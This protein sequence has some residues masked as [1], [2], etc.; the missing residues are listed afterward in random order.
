MQENDLAPNST[1]S[2]GAVMNLPDTFETEKAEEE[3]S[4]IICNKIC[5][6]NEIELNLCPNHFRCEDCSS[7]HFSNQKEIF[8]KGGGF[9]CYRCDFLI[10]KEKYNKFITSAACYRCGENIRSKFD[11]ILDQYNICRKCNGAMIM[12]RVQGNRSTFQQKKIIETCLICLEQKTMSSS[13]CSTH[14]VC[15]SC[16]AEYLKSSITS[17]FIF[18]ASFS[19]P[20]PKGTCGTLFSSQFIQSYIGH[21]EEFKKWFERSK[22]K[23]SC[24]KCS[25][26][27]V[28]IRT[29]DSVWCKKCNSV[30][31]AIC[32]KQLEQVLRVHSHTRHYCALKEDLSLLNS[33]R[34]TFPLKPCLKCLNYIYKADGC[35][36]M[37]CICGGSFCWECLQPYDQH[38]QRKCKKKNGILA[39]YFTSKLYVYVYA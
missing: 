25:S 29:N 38:D 39:K 13:S 30:F 3:K 15:D 7:L 18:G 36:H 33:V 22:R 16:L 17:S 12:D 9:T 37:T 19:C 5:Y 24:S 6:L 14:Q 27:D 21:T 2:C 34:S 32:F 35:S 8:K 23:F 4:C 28:K 31:C 1:F 11:M 10:P 20:G 26:E